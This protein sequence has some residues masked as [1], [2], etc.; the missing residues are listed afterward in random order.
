MF[1]IPGLTPDIFLV[2]G[3]LIITVILFVTEIVRVDVVACLVLVLLGLTKL[4]PSQLLFSGFSSDAVI[5]LIGVMIMCAGLERSGVV[6]KI[7]HY[8]M[9]LGGSDE[10][11][12]RLLL[13]GIGGFFAGFLR[14]VGTV[15]LLLPVV[16]RI[17]HATGIDKRRLLMPLSF[18]AILGSTLTMLGTGPLIL[19]N[20]LLANSGGLTDKYGQAAPVL[21]LFSVFPI[22]LMLLLLGIGYFSLLGNWVLPK[23]LL[24]V[25]SLDSSGPTYFKRIYG[26]G[27]DFCECRLPSTSSLVNNTLRQWEGLLPPDIAIIGVK[28][29]NNMHIPPLRK[30]ELKEGTVIAML[31]PKEAIHEFAKKYGLRMSPYLTVFSE[32]LNPTHSG[33]CEAVV[34]PSSQLIGT[35]LRDLHMRHHFRIQVLAVHR[36]DK[37][38]RGK[39]EIGNLTLRSGDTLGM[40][41]EWGALFSLRK[42]PDFVVVTSGYPLQKMHTEKM[43]FAVFFF[44]LAIGL[45]VFGGFSVAIGLLVGAVCMIF[46]GVISIDDAYE[47]VS[48][49]TVFLL[50]GLMPLGIAVQTSGTSDWIAMYILKVFSGSSEWLLL[51][52]LGIFASICSLILSNAG[53]TIVL[54]PLA[55]H[56]AQAI[57]ADP[58]AFALM[59]AVA[60]SNAFVLPTHQ[61]NALI[62]LPGQYKVADFLRAGGLMSLL[63]LIVVMLMIHWLF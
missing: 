12:I 22:G 57:G 46:S 55:V 11:R 56:L 41:C 59:V 9:R 43:W 6:A 13:M 50:A 33:L 54:V 24:R 58:R 62:S 42:N 47:A 20:S 2:F 40:F 31:G 63:Y 39:K 53:A 3:I 34:P 14:S 23:V 25:N 45:I 15:A 48:W 52:M 38:R 28:A 35:N 16:M 29:G 4:V 21:G 44:S 36:G 60:T 37:V 27:A 10:G 5:A 1:G 7:T 26:I 49:K 19:L 61:A 18:C 30:T 8:M 32:R 17:R 51:F